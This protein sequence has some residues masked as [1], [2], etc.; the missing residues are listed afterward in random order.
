MDL[1]LLSPSQITCIVFLDTVHSTQL[2]FTPL[3][4]FR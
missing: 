1:F 2:E 3:K 4:T